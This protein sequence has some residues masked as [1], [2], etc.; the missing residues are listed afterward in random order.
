[1]KS[2]K[3]LITFIKTPRPM[4]TLAIAICLIISLTVRSQSLKKYPISN[5]GCSYYGYCEPGKWDVDK[6]EDSSDV[7]TSECKNGD[8]NYGVI[9]VKLKEPVS[10]IEQAQD[11]VVEYLDYLKQ[12]FSVKKAV[13]Y[14]KGNYLNNDTNTR[15]VVD[16]WEDADKNSYK[17]KAWTNGKFIAVLFAYSLK[18]LP[19]T[20]VDVFL[21]GLRF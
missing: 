4:R 7:W 1:M 20:K 21:N 15:G 12:S 18:P 17:V 16:Y 14:G 13:G 11:I 9:C 5:S 6:S 8:V 10:D 3:N 2:T 19:E